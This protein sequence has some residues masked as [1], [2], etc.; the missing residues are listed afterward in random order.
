MRQLINLINNKVSISY[1]V[2]C[3]AIFLCKQF[4]NIKI[5]RHVIWVRPF[6]RNAA[7]EHGFFFNFIYARIKK[8]GSQKVRTS[9]P[10]PPLKNSDF[11]KLLNNNVPL[12][13]LPPT[14]RRK[15]FLNS[16]V[17]TYCDLFCLTVRKMGN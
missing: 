3:Y 16:H 8:G 6:Y 1:I 10:P 9:P 17:S 5:C 15:L 7:N 2:L 11:L 12:T 13:P 14:P 4:S